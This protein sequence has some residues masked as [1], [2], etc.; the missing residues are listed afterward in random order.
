MSS[1]AIIDLVMP[2]R[3][4]NTRCKLPYPVKT[5]AGVGLI[6]QTGQLCS[7]LIYTQSGSYDS[8]VF[9]AAVTTA[10]FSRGQRV[11]VIL[12]GERQAEIIES[13]LPLS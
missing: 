9:Q 10:S 3:D 7:G 5:V 6:L 2:V 1:S 8:L 11:L 4:E 12:G 13:E